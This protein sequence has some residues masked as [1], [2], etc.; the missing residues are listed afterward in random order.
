[1]QGSVHILLNNRMQYLVT[2]YWKMMVEAWPK[3]IEV[4][5]YVSKLTILCSGYQS[6]ASPVAHCSYE[7]L[8]PSGGS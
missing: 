1:M 3:I 8:K 5:I 2:H 7:Q 4:Q 6:I